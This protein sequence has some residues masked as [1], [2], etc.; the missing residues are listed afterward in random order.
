MDTVAV[1]AAVDYTDYGRIR[2]WAAQQS[3]KQMLV[4]VTDDP[5]EQNAVL[6]RQ[7]RCYE[8]AYAVVHM[9]A[10]VRSLADMQTAQ[11]RRN[12]VMLEM[13]SQ[14]VTFGGFE[15][16]DVDESKVTRL[17]ERDSCPK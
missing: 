3:Q 4:L 11:A 6:V 10:V 1:F 12:R 17:I 8:V 13:A 14:V 9:S 5:S 16:P 15:I 7:L 2:V